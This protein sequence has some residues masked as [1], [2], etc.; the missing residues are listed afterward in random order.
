MHIGPTLAKIPKS[1]D[2]IS[3]K[4][5]ILVSRYTHHNAIQRMAW[6]H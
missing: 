3:Y 4:A 1:I 5:F 6:K 2:N